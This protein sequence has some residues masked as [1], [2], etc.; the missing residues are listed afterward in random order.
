MFVK[1]EPKYNSDKMPIVTT[2]AQLAQNPM[3]YAVFLLDFLNLKKMFT[4]MYANAFKV[5]HAQNIELRKKL[6]E[7]NKKRTIV[8][9]TDWELNNVKQVPNCE[10]KTENKNEI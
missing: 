4:K 1:P 7:I 9:L 5:G 10:Q 8:N 6:K 2:S 3:L